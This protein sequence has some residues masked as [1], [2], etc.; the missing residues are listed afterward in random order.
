M[1]ARYAPPADWKQTSL[2][3]LLEGT[4]RGLQPAS[5][6][7][8]RAGERT[9]FVAGDVA[10]L[11]LACVSVIGS[12][13]VSAAGEATALPASGV[14]SCASTPAPG[15][16]NPPPINATIANLRIRMPIIFA[17]SSPSRPI[18]A[19]TSRPFLP[20]LCAIVNR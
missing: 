4:G 1:A 13:R 5:G 6:R 2:G 17:R 7:K 8:T 12:R 18:D 11:Q 19:S 9:V 16:N 3:S 20:C 10:L 15:S 14:A